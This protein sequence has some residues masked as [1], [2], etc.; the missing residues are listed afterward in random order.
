[1]A[2]DQEPRSSLERLQE[3]QQLRNVEP[4]HIKS[5]TGTESSTNPIPTENTVVFDP[6]AE[7]SGTGSDADGGS[8]S[9]AG[10]GQEG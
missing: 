9:S 3:N 4:S 2:E 8:D 1:M 5:L 10:K 6:P 7:S